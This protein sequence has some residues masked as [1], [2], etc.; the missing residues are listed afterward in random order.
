M[1]TRE[2]T[3]KAGKTL[4][5]PAKISQER[6]GTRWHKIDFFISFLNDMEL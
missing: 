1:A 6:I 2:N 4:F 3:K 5:I